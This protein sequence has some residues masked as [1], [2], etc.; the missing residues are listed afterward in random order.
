MAA[1]SRNTVESIEAKVADL[2][3]RAVSE[4][5]VDVGA[6]QLKLGLKRTAGAKRRRVMNE[7]ISMTIVDSATGKMLAKDTQ[8]VPFH[9]LIARTHLLLAP[10][11][12]IS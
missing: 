10:L 4:S 11:R 6:M 9:R 5:A 8:C 3:S 7:V 1:A 2:L 12:V